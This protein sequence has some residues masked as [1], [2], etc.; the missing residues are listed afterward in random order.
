MINDDFVA[1]LC[2]GTLVVIC[3]AA[4]LLSIAKRAGGLCP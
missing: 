3:I 2:A 1:G 4:L